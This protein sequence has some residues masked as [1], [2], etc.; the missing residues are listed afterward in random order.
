M[1]RVR[2]PRCGSENHSRINSRR[3]K[4]QRLA[5][6]NTVLR[7]HR[8]QGCCKEFHTIQTPIVG[9]M[10]EAVLSVLGV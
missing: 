2:C 3:Y 10:A 1:S 8:C 7:A 9:E 6:F 5:D 4:S